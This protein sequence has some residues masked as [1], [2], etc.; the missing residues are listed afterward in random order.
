VTL[1]ANDQTQSTWRLTNLFLA[2]HWTWRTLA[3]QYRLGLGVTLPTAQLPSDRADSAIAQSGYS[4]RSAMKGWRE[5]WLYAP[6][7]A[8]F[9]GHADYYWRAP[10]GLIVGGAVVAGIMV[11]TSDTPFVPEDLVVVQAEAEIAYDTRY[12]RSSLTAG[13]VSFPVA[14]EIEVGDDALQIAIEPDFRIRLGEVDLLLGLTLPID[15]PAGFGFSE[16]GFWAVRIGIANG[17]SLLLPEE[18]DEPVE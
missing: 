15:K 6:E 12:V 10:S 3:Q 7:S 5:A 16:E 18:D 14:E 4:V 17:T 11:R 9:T 1:A 13:L 2:H 8:A